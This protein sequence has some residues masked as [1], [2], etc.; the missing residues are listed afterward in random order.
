GVAQAELRSAQINLDYCRVAA[1][2]PARVA[3]L[4]ISAGE[5]ARQG[6][7]LF[8]LVDTRR[9]YVVANFRATFLPSIRAGQDVE[10][11]L[12]PYPHRR[13]RG[14]VQG[15]GWAIRT[16]DSAPNGTLLE[17][18]PELNWVRLAQRVPVRIELEPPDAQTPYRMGMTAV[19]TVRKP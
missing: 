4:N 6:E 2:F 15:V 13:F 10:V 9:W 17:V 1:P 16:Q 5:F 12:M 19:V 8:A 14:T 18:K 3:N 7:P 11:Y